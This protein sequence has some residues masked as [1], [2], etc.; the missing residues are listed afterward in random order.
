MENEMDHPALI[1]FDGVCN[2]CNASVQFI[3][4]RDPDRYFRFASLQ[5]QAGKKMLERHR[6]GF[7]LNTF[8][9]VEDGRAYTR[10]EAVLRVARRLKS[11]WRFIGGFRVIPLF[12]RDA[13][14]NLVAKNRYR[15]FGKQESCMLPTPE[16]KALFLDRDEVVQPVA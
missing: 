2:L 3:I 4:E 1:L 5:S 11:P 10:S 14:Y 13:V 15:M 7:D 8:V 6:I 12:L 16:L 9:L